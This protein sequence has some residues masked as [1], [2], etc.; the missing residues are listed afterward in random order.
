MEKEIFG[1]L[2][3]FLTFLG[4][5]YGLITTKN[6]LDKFYIY[7]ILLL[8]ISWTFFNG[9]CLYSLLHKTVNRIESTH[10]RA[11]DMLLWFGDEKTHDTF[12]LACSIFTMLSIMRVFYRNHI[13]IPLIALLI[14]FA[15]IYVQAIKKYKNRCSNVS[16]LTIQSMLKLYCMYLLVYVYYK[17]EIRM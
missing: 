5:T 15:F 16:F 8:Y 14:G 11:D 7:Y 4:S 3:I 9:E 6:W 1:L 10:A 2:H 13:P 12:I 17:L